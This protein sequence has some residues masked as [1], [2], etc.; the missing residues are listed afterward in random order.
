MITYVLCISVYF[1]PS[2]AVIH[3][4]NFRT[5]QGWGHIYT[6]RYNYLLVVLFLCWS[7]SVHA[8]LCW[9]LFGLYWSLIAV[10]ISVNL[11]KSFVEALFVFREDLV[12]MQTFKGGMVQWVA[13]LTRN[14][15][16][17]DSSPIKGPRCFLEQETLPLL[18]S[19]GWF[20]ERI[21]AW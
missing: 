13:R 1:S 4:L 17:V 6:V 16:V 20:Q 12:N 10:F 2:T 9:S 3:L 11:E 7:I 18:L 5:A 14:V 21:R 15:E 19:T 8:G